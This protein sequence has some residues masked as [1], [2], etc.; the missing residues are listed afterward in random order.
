MNTASPEERTTLD[1]PGSPGAS[2]ASVA[3]YV[4]ADNQSPQCAKALLS[5]FRVDLDA[6]VVSATIAGNNHGQQ[7][8]RSTAGAVSWSPRSPMSWCERLPCLTGSRR[9]MWLC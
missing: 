6:R 1:A 3:L 4:D 2:S 5:L 7:V 9:R 8:N